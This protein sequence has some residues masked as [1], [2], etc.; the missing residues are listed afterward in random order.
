MDKQQP[1]RDNHLDTPSEAN[2]DGHINFMEVE[3]A[4]GHRSRDDPDR[5]NEFKKAVRE[6]EEEKVRE[7]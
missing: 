2:H 1:P 5:D 4:N 7:S 3:E 6:A